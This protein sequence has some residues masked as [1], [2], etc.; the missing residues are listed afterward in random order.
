MLKKLI[1]FTFVILAFSGVK[2]TNAQYYVWVDS[3]AVTTTAQ[4]STFDTRWEEV[5]IKFE[6]C[7]GL[8]KVGSPDVGSW[9]SRKFFPV[10]DGETIRFGFRTPLKRL[11][12]K[13]SSGSGTI[14]FIGYK[15]SAQY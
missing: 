8:I 15:K 10:A 1:I 9:G 5:T 4:D 6:G 13:A 11:K 3:L 12:F 2:N 14:H 7:D